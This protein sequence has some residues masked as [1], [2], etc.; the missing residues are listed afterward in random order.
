[1]KIKL[2]LITTLALVWLG[3]G[4]S[5]VA[6]VANSAGDRDFHRSVCQAGSGIRCHAD[7]VTNHKGTP[8]SA[9]APV[10]LTPAQIHGAY[11]LPTVSTSSSAPVIAIIDA[12][13]DPYIKSDLDKYNSTFGLPQFPSCSA[14]ITSAC[15]QKLNQRG[16]STYP[17]ANAGWSL[18]I[19]LDVETAHQICQNC[20]L[21][22]VEADSS[23]YTNLMAAV[24][25]AR[26][27][28]AKI[29]SNSYG[30]SE[31]SGETAYDS[32][33]NYPGT[34]F[35]FSSGD[36]GYGPTYPAASPYVVSVGGTTLSL[37]GN[38]WLAE[39]A[40]SGSGSGCSIY[41]AKPVFQTDAG[42]SMRTIADVSAVADPNSG[43]AVYDSMRYQ[44]QKG[45]FKVGGTSLAAPLIAGVYALAGNIGTATPANSVPYAQG[46]NLNLHD[47][48]TGSNGTC[49]VS[50]LCTGVSGYDGPTGLG[51][52]SGLD[53]F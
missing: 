38:N 45:W 36:N 33:F 15:F 31:F 5:L 29:I 14:S 26:L 11:N 42:C 1:M 25:R 23:S 44:G 35:T 2:T 34:V 17:S 52:P 47:V 19:A 30:S 48:V 28:G 43:A 12:Y 49:P 46:S 37:S 7:V 8:L 4:W 53:A 10:G 40:W 39:S 32:Y 51:S 3:L 27:V 50:Y 41:E 21:I 9:T 6:G 16:G 20:K 13:D 24:D 18:E 22:L